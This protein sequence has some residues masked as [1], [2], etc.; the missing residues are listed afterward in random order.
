MR[1]STLTGP[2][3]GDLSLTLCATVVAAVPLVAQDPRLSRVGQVQI[4]GN[5]ISF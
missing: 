5:I 4:G 1:L 3:Y 2:P